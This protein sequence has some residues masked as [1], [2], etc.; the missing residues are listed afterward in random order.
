M[1]MYQ[2]VAGLAVA[3][4]L[5]AQP[6]PG[7]FGGPGGPGG[8]PG[9]PTFTE[10][11]AYL[12]LTDSQ[13]T[14]LQ[15]LRQQE[16][17][18]VKTDMDT[19]RA[20]QTELRAAVDKGDAATAGKLL[21]EISAIHKRIADARTRYYTNAV[22]VLTAAQK[23]KLQALEEAAKLMPTI[24]QA[25]ALNLLTQPERP[26]GAG[27][28]GMGPGGMGMGPGGMGMG[29]GGMGFGGGRIVR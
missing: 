21:V 9:T 14:S 22:A 25:R 10:I 12:T 13:V 1:K 15:Q 4:G 19:V 8:G 26:A 23:T 27:P 24:G 16:A 5:M 20:K 17:E 3:A 28:M 7:G 2:M 18:A 29:P 11:K 6:G